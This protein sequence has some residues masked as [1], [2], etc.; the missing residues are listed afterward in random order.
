[1]YRQAIDFY[2]WV[3]WLLKLL[4]VSGFLLEYL[5]FPM[6][7]YDPLKIW[8]LFLF[9][10]LIATAQC[11]KRERE[12]DS[13]HSL[14]T[15]LVLLQTFL[16]SERCW[17]YVCIIQFLLFWGRFSLTLQSLRLLS[18]SCVGFCQRL[19]LHIWRWLCGF[20][21]GPMYVVYYV[22]KF[23]YVELSHSSGI[24]QT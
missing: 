16:H 23:K 19:F 24:K 10:S 3:L 11:S 20:V 1:M 9:I 8:L 4:F 7:K 5:K 22:Y 2:I 21:F 15:S 18:Y 12:L 6:Q 17:L 13:P 14:L